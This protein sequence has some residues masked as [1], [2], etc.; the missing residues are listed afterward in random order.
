MKARPLRNPLNGL[1]LFKVSP[2]LV[3]KI[4]MFSKHCLRPHNVGVRVYEIC[5]ILARISLHPVRGKMS[6]VIFQ[7]FA[8][9]PLGEP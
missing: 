1:P 7:Y 4:L 8:L 3:L 2:I 6:P 5:I 9:A